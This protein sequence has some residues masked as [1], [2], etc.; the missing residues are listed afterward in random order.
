[1]GLNMLTNLKYSSVHVFLILSTQLASLHIIPEKQILKASKNKD[2]HANN[3]T[4]NTMHYHNNSN[5]ITYDHN[6]TVILHVKNH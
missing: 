2:Y 4:I 5:S 3:N 1:M 6:N